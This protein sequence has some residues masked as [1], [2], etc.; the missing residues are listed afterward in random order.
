MQAKA[1]R[2][3]LIDGFLIQRVPYARTQGLPARSKGQPGSA[4]GPWGGLP[5]PRPSLWRGGW[6]AATVAIPARES[7]RKE[8]CYFA[9]FETALPADDTSFPAPWTVLQAASVASAAMMMAVVIFVCMTDPLT[10]CE[11]KHPQGESFLR[12]RCCE[13]ERR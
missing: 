8:K 10:V 6:F 1:G 11:P 13:Q 7:S 2:D 3:I 12:V 5:F 4:R 9:A